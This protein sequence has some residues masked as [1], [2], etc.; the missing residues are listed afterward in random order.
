LHKTTSEEGKRQEGNEKGE[1]HD[2]DKMKKDK[3]GKKDKKDKDDKDDK[4]KDKPKTKRKD[5]L[6]PFRM[7]FVRIN[8]SFFLSLALSLS[9]RL[10]HPCPSYPSCLSYPFSFVMVVLLAFF[11]SF[12]SFSFF[13]LSSCARTAALVKQS[14][15]SAS[16]SLVD[17]FIMVSFY[18]YRNITIK[19]PFHC[20]FR[21]TKK[22]AP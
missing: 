18:V 5:D 3:K 4:D 9:C 16:K 20:H 6:Q 11:I 17:V 15:S 21:Q 2:H 8:R 13:A 22:A 14:N 19:R 12:L 1:K 7:I 10:Y